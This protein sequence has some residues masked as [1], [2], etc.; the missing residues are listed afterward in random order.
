MNPVKIH[1][2]DELF[3]GAT[4][5]EDNWNR[6]DLPAGSAKWAVDAGGAR[7]SLMFTCPCGCGRINAV[8]VKPANP[9]G[10]SW[11]G[12]VERPTLHPSILITVGCRWHGY[13][14]GG[15]WRKC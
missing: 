10:W 5:V 15:E 4:V 8:G 6:R 12:N 7:A 9:D 11:D 13:L 3:D 2:V 1:F 14:I